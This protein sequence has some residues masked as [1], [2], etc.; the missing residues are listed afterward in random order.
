[1]YP[2]RGWGIIRGVREGGAG[3]CGTRVGTPRGKR[4]VTRNIPAAADCLPIVY[5]RVYPPSA[6]DAYLP[7]VYPSVYPPVRGG[8]RRRRR[9][10]GVGRW[11]VVMVRQRGLVKRRCTPGPHRRFPATAAAAV[12]PGLWVEDERAAHGSCPRTHPRL[13]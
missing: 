2:P 9:V 6:A 5:P 12:A 1:V 8:E 11:R 13:A 3:P 7:I 4:M 10:V